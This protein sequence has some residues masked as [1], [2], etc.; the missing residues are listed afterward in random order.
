MKILYTQG[1]GKFEEKDYYLTELAPNKI[2][3]RSHMTGVCRSDI[4]M[5]MGKFE[6]LPIE[7]SGHEGLGIVEQIGSEITN[8]KV[9]DYVATRG[10]PAYADYYHCKDYVKVPELHPRYILEPI[11]CS[12]NIILQKQ[13]LLGKKN[14]R[15]LIVGSGLLAWVV[16]NTIKILDYNYN[17]TVIGNHNKN[18]WG[19]IL[20]QEYTGKFDVVIDLGSK[21]LF[22]QDIYNPDALY[23][24]AAQKQTQ[25][26][27]RYLLWNA[28]SI[29]CP[30]PRAS[31]FNRAMTLARDWIQSGELNVDAFW[32]KGYDRHTEWES[33]FN[34]GKQRTLNYNRGYIK[35]R[36]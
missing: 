14:G 34:D 29:I 33:A 31:T 16:Y 15:M 35:W 17:I 19:D 18:I 9:G 24:Y 30:S 26:D 32:T 25:T 21:D 12:I 7:M 6:L 2:L 3:V 36:T 5:M 13:S 11:A 1:Q 8:V 23:Y 4:D 22:N 20:Q 27:L 10:E 28:V